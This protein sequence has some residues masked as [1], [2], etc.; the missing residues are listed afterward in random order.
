MTSEGIYLK[1]VDRKLYRK[2]KSTAAERGV[3]VY[4]V[5]NEAIAAYVVSMSAEGGEPAVMSQGEL[6]NLAYAALEADP[7]MIGKWVG[8][9]NG[10]MLAAS[11]TEE[12]V[13]GVMRKE[14][15]TR[16]FVHGIVAKVGEQ[17]GTGEWLAG[18]LRQE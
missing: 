11:D 17:R 8:I 9:A 7:S 6:D 1:K 5:L 16:P 12:N 4:Q 10:K 14:Y 13:L 2:L 18:S 3:P 15:S